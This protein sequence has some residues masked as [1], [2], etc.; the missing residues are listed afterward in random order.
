MVATWEEVIKRQKRID[1]QFTLAT[2]SKSKQQP[3]KKTQ[4]LKETLPAISWE[5]I[6]ER[7]KRLPDNYSIEFDNRS[8]PQRFVDALKSVPD[9]TLRAGKY[10]SSAAKGSAVRL[11][12]GA[13]QAG[14][15]LADMAKSRAGDFVV[16]ALDKLQPEAKL[17][18]RLQD[19]KEMERWRQGLREQASRG[20][21]LPGWLATELVTGETEAIA[22]SRH[23]IQKKLA[24]VKRESGQF[25]PV[26]QK[27]LKEGKFWHPAVVFEQGLDTGGQLSLA[28][29]ANLAVPGSGLPL[30]AAW[31]AGS[32]REDTLERLR[33]QATENNINWDRQQA[34]LIADGEAAISG[35]S[36]LVT[37]RLPLGM[38][39][40]KAGKKLVS[41][42]N[43][44]VARKLVGLT[45]SASAE[46][47]E[48]IVDGTVQDLA[49]WYIENDKPAVK[50]F[51][52]SR[53]AEGLA[54]FAGGAAAHVGI[55]T[56]KKL[57]NRSKIRADKL[58]SDIESLLETPDGRQKLR[59]LA[60]K[61]NPTRDDIKKAGIKTKLRLNAGERKV[62]ASAVSLE[63]FDTEQQVWRKIA[64]LPSKPETE[65]K[66]E[67]IGQTEQSVQDT[68]ASE[69]PAVE[70]NT[71][72][73]ARIEKLNKLNTTYQKAK[74][75]ALEQQN[76]YAINSYNRLIAENN[77]T[78]QKLNDLQ[79]AATDTA[80][81]KTAEPPRVEPKPVT[82]PILT[83]TEASLK[84]DVKYGLFSRFE[85]SGEKLKNLLSKIGDVILGPVGKTKTRKFGSKVVNL[86]SKQGALD[87][88]AHLAKQLKDRRLARHSQEL[89]QAIVD[90]QTGVK[91]TAGIPDNKLLPS[92]LSHLADQY[93]KG[94]VEL[95]D[96]PQ[97]MQVP[98]K[99]LREKINDLSR[100]ALNSGA[101]TGEI[102]GS[103]AHRTK[104]FDQLRAS[105]KAGTER[106]DVVS[107][108]IKSGMQEKMAGTVT[109]ILANDGLYLTRTFDAFEDAT[110]RDRIP[111][112][113][114]QDMIGYLA[115]KFN[116]ERTKK[117]LAPQDADHPAMAKKIEREMNRILQKALDAGDMRVYMENRLGR[118]NRNT[119]KQRL[120]LP[121]EYKAFLGEV[122]EPVENVIKT[123]LKLASLTE[124]YRFLS[125]IREAGLGE[126]LWAEGDESRPVDAV[127]KLADK[128]DLSMMP[129]A[130]L[131]TTPEFKEAFSTPERDF[132]NAPFL[133][134]AMYWLDTKAQR[135]KTAWS[136]QSHMRQ[137]VGDPIMMAANGNWGHILPFFKRKPST[138]AAAI[139]GKGTKNQRQYLNRATELGLA[140]EGIEYGLFN[141]FIRKKPIDQMIIETLGK[142][143][144]KLPVNID[145]DVLG[146]FA[147]KN[148]GYTDTAFKLY[149]WEAE[150]A[151]YRKT[152]MFEDTPEGERALEEYAAKI[153]RDTNPTYSDLPPIIQA[154]RDIPGFGMFMAFPA[155]QIRNAVKRA[156]VTATELS[157]ENP[158]V[159][160]IG[161]K[162]AISQLA[163]YSAPYIAEVASAAAASVSD[164]ER[165]AFNK[166][167][168]WYARWGP[169]LF[170]GRN[171]KG[172]IRYIN[173]G[174]IDPH[175][176]FTQPIRLLL[177][178]ASEGEF[179]KS[180]GQA[181]AQAFE[182]YLQET[183]AATAAFD[184]AR[185][186]TQFGSAIWEKNDHPLTKAMKAA[187]H[188]Y[189]GT[190]E[191]GT[192]IS[193]ENIYKGYQGEVSKGGK[194]YN[195]RDEAISAGTGFKIETY[196]PSQGFKFLVNDFVNG[197]KSSRA[198]LYRDLAREGY[199]S[200][201]Q[202]T[203]TIKRHD[204]IRKTAFDNF[205][206]QYD[207]YHIIDPERLN[208]AT[209][210]SSLKSRRVSDDDIEQAYTGK[211]KSYI[212][213]DIQILD[214]MIKVTDGDR[215][216]ELVAAKKV[217]LART[218]YNLGATPSDENFVQQKEQYKTLH[219]QNIS[220]NDALNLATQHMKTTSLNSTIRSIKS[221]VGDKYTDEQIIQV[222]TAK[223]Y[224]KGFNLTESRLLRFHNIA[225][226]YGL[227]TS[228]LLDFLKGTQDNE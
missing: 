35:I 201:A 79:T 174:Y 191:T 153:V 110:W 134:R 197:L 167:L 200:D 137:V 146:R 154:I 194:V 189:Y 125:D 217:R 112:S 65:N 124:N 14:F 172:E 122:K 183:M 144:G 130:G 39:G 103:V 138:Y 114:R 226:R 113:V 94:N 86:F 84:V 80:Q 106:K 23:K 3:R 116:A 120:D 132:H 24:K 131:W 221:K 51:V 119:L 81:P 205:S 21:G 28:I 42:I 173:L 95:D 38:I 198:V 111:D 22:D 185:N 45:A 128:N 8:V 180:I 171:D 104:I 225:E 74:E 67:K 152:G 212:P 11:A 9:E 72:L 211:T 177:Q 50:E 182:P 158:K 19:P 149:G 129:V 40:G 78:I 88:A 222:A 141:R 101:V 192:Q 161:L 60:E 32:T 62:L 208:K 159:R 195:A 76:I 29:G 102:F 75:N 202:V 25:S 115:E 10:L 54:G 136:I 150:K 147:R 224:A 207:N 49:K 133:V 181:A 2:L 162:R 55:N 30:L 199:V 214:R 63:E 85:L 179:V 118:Q 56:G 227:E 16:Y 20:A 68:L 96:L 105:L 219:D 93:L 18:E 140:S 59:N 61:E 127:V 155:S 70:D 90:Y 27:A 77:N 47:I 203:Q 5:K 36:A 53:L 71:H 26:A 168:P 87:P 98:T 188:A 107:F 135:A 190:I 99:A 215:Q 41:K 52:Q 169:K 58:F 193:L 97:E 160:A 166:T 206:K 109:S 43:N 156:Q 7:K 44:S 170:F 64:D 139:F 218:A 48:E 157:S 37:E 33:E 164:E 89:R 216:K 91:K 73:N 204:I 82:P 69:N 108:L 163:V 184:L 145:A 148:Y 151:K 92:N 213:T 12:T 1:D 165:E 186:R 176:Y 83:E 117:D 220:A 66:D 196:N 223:E 46:G 178:G 187:S 175:A 209:L 17:R 121:S 126:F 210:I 15:S 31:Q 143:P 4:Q 228:E 6:Q 57:H 100:A 34:E 142:K 123:G 13:A